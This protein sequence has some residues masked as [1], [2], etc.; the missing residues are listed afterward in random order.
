MTIIK[1]R[2]TLVR[3]SQGA[4]GQPRAR[5]ECRPKPRR[6]YLQMIVLRIILETRKEGKQTERKWVRF[7]PGIEHV[8]APAQVR[9]TRPF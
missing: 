7:S 1:L 8:E 3:G 4:M 5:Q 6:E 2:K 9:I